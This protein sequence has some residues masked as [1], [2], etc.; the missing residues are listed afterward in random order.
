M[1]HVSIN[2]R[3]SLLPTREGT[4]RG[5]PTPAMG[6]W[7]GLVHPSSFL[8]VNKKTKWMGVGEVG[9]TGRTAVVYKAFYVA[10]RVMRVDIQQ[11][12]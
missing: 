9:I 8:V 10:G 5:V 2:G 7:F 1:P 12:R 6:G 4:D 3:G 11:G